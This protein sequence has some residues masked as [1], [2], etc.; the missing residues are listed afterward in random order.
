LS[1][2][3][4]TNARPPQRGKEPWRF[5]SV[6]R[7]TPHLGEE[8]KVPWIA[9]I[10]LGG[11]ILVLAIS[12]VVFA[13]LTVTRTPSPAVLATMTAIPPTQ[14]LMSPTLLPTPT[15]PTAT[16]RPTATNTLPP[17]TSTATVPPPTAAFVKYR[18]RPGDTLSAI[19]ETYRVTIRSIMLANGLRNQTIYVGQELNIPRPTPRP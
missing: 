12:G 19:A 2:Q 11:V 1:S 17:A 8:N 9:W 3:L 10:I 13:L 6:S 7:A 18:V 14:T 4:P 15:V 5:R 16:S